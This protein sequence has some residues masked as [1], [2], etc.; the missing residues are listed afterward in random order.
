MRESGEEAGLI[1]EFSRGGRRWESVGGRPVAPDGGT[2]QCHVGRTSHMNGTG[3]ATR[4]FIQ[5]PLCGVIQECAIQ[6]GSFVNN[7]HPSTSCARV[8]GGWALELFDSLSAR[9]MALAHRR[10]R[11][12]S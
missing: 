8:Y 6:T 12:T 3:C 2:H 4:R 11:H 1:Y 9:A 5:R 10:N 7:T